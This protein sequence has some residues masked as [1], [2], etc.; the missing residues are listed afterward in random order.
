M[1]SKSP[2]VDVSQPGE[3][4]CPPLP[5]EASFSPITPPFYLSITP[6][7]HASRQNIFF[8]RKLLQPR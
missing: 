3:F 5:L 2:N 4:K 7:F 6:G 8:Y 1:R